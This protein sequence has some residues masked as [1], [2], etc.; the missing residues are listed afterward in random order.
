MKRSTPAATTVEAE[1]L[2]ERD[3]L[4]LTQEPGLIDLGH[5]TQLG[6]GAARHLGRH[7]GA[8]GLSGLGDLTP[9]DAKFLGQHCDALVLDGLHSLSTAAAKGL[10]RHRGGLSLRGLHTLPPAVARG[11]AGACG[12][13]RLDGLATLGP[14]TAGAL[15]MHHGSLHLDGIAVLDDG[16][17]RS[18]AAHRGDLFLRGVRSLGVSAARLL[19]SHR[20]RL[21]LDGL[22]ELSIEAA[23]ALTAHEGCLS[24]DGLTSLSV[25]LAEALGHQRGW[26]SL[27]GVRALDSATF[28]ALITHRGW[29]ALTGLT[30]VPEDCRVL[31]AAH[32]R[33]R[34]PGC[35]VSAAESQRPASAARPAADA[36]PVVGVAIIGTGFSGL[37]MAM[38]LLKEGR[39]DFLIFEKAGSLGGTWRDNAYPGCACDI[40]SHLYSYS[41]AASADWSRRYAAQPEILAYLER[42]ARDHRIER[43]IR[44]NTAIT[45]LTWDDTQGLWRLTTADGREFRA[46]VVIAAVGGIHL[47]AMP[48]I[49]GLDT[50]AGPMFHTSRW[51]HDLDL[52]GRSVALIGTGASSVQVAPELAARVGR[53]AVFQ[54]SPAWVLPRRDRRFS[55]LAHWA[56][57]SLPGAARWQRLTEFLAAEMRAIPLFVNPKLLVHG[58]RATDKFL[59][60]SI[61]Q[62][63]IR[64]KLI[65]RY[66]MGCKRILFSDDFYPALARE[67]VEL[68]TEAIEEI[69]PW[70]VVTRGGIER[71]I[72][73]VVV[74]T[75][76]KPFNI[77][78]GIA[79]SGRGGLDLAEVWRGG[80]EAFRGVTLSGFPNLFL[81]M[82]P[83]TALAHNSI[84]IMIEAQVRYIL[85]CL[86]WLRDG[87]LE[88]VEV[89]PEAQRRYNEDLARRFEHTPWDE[90][91]A[92]AGRGRRFV[93]CTTWYRHASGKNHVLWPG[94][95]LSYQATM[96]RADIGDFLAEPTSRGLRGS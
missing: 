50:F 9:E 83:N 32:R 84:V 72:D 69:R 11:L 16:V 42:V 81:I 64:S 73:A 17:A 26:L 59:K 38:G 24:L 8:L 34:L 56:V 91:A 53:L 76:F 65:P 85:Q 3:A 66:T 89:R 14:A 93:P 49:P 37:G 23:L 31:A 77:T 45:A 86:G 4:G 63:Q 2:A 61:R 5:V 92:P 94:S 82:G 12:D 35:R 74:A 60:R 19:A 30:A 36:E 75:G 67:H 10:G 51:R 78:D 52:E 6:P 58:Q 41:F 43:F 57:R 79:I 18:L 96:R 87:R 70:S 44:F 22:T 20:G 55:A 25:P 71:A 15:A 13:L 29:L 80:P 7:G 48:A 27:G 1:W 33:L 40:P 54:R 62:R 39:S 21:G 68:V 47:P 90:H 28:R 95:S 46:R 88:T